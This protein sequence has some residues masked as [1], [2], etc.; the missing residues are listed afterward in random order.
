MQP[1]L[2]LRNLPF[3][4]DHTSHLNLPAS[5]ANI[6]AAVSRTLVRGVAL[7]FSRPVRLF[8]PSKVSGWHSLRN[9]ATKGNTELSTRFL[10]SL[11]KSEGVRHLNQNLRSLIFMVAVYGDT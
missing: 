10:T 7:Y 8:R 2:V 11:V 1:P 5:A 4:S 6:Q 3:E 9:I